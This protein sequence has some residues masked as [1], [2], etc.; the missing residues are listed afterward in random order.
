MEEN[1]GHVKTVLDQI[2]KR[3][4]EQAATSN[5]RYE[6]Q[7]AFNAQVSQELH[8]VRKQIDLTQADVDEARQVALPTSSSARSQF[9]EQRGA[10]FG[11]CPQGAAQDMAG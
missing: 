3:L 4:D 7:T 8:G 5:Q 1:A 2:L 6:V 9:P 10:A 11:P